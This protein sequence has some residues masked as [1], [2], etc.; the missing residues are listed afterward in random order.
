MSEGNPMWMS[1]IRTATGPVRYVMTVPTDAQRAAAAQSPLYQIG[2]ALLIWANEGDL[3]RR[4]PAEP[5]A[6]CVEAMRMAERALSW[7]LATAK[8]SDN[9][10]IA[11]AAIDALRAQIAQIG[12]GR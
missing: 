5:T 8:G 1:D 9:V 11:Q 12:G 3:C 7:L 2:D 6:A 10:K 4:A